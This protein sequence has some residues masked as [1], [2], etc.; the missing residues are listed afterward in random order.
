MNIQNKKNDL[1]LNYERIGEGVNIRS[2]RKLSEVG[3]KST[4]FFRN[5]KKKQFV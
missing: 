2:K 5:P 4:K 3:K 1:E